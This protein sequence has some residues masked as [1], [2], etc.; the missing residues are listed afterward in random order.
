MVGPGLWNC[1]VSH[2]PSFRHHVA[3]NLNTD[4]ED[5][6][7]ESGQCPYN[8][9]ECR[10]WVDVCGRCYKV[11]CDSLCDGW[12]HCPMNDDEMLCGITCPVNCLCQVFTDNYK[13]CCDGM[14]PAA[15]DPSAC[16]APKDEISSCDDLLPSWTYR[17]SL[18]L[19]ACLSVTGNGFCFW[20]RLL[21][22]SM[23]S[24]S[25]FGVFVTNLTIADFLMGVYIVIIGVADERSRGKYLHYDEAWKSSVVCKAAGFLSLLSSEVSALIICVIT[26]DRFLVLRFP[27]STL[28][29]SRTSAAIACLF[30]WLVG[31]LLAS[32]PLLPVTLHWKFY[33]R[34][35]I[36]IPLPI[37]GDDFKGRVYSFSVLI[38]LNFVLFLFIS[39][40]QAFIYWSVQD[41]AMK[42]NT[43]RMS[44]DL[45]IARRLI[46][47]AISDFMCWFPIGVCGMLALAGIPIPG[48]VNVSLAVFILPLNSAVNPFLYTF[49]TL[50]EKQRKAEHE[51]LLKWLTLHSDTVT[52]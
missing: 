9:P 45:T 41:N 44:R 7:D 12:P 36:C 46:S 43:T 49:N 50:A 10:E 1:S 39:A 33:S 30:V 32:V 31:L 3:C 18:W 16:H 28:R 24:P 21:V 40:G 8:H 2:Y 47:V 37:M 25:G 13:L 27:F 42:T 20:A 4:C 17:G 38:A 19:M 11:L 26:L 51:R 23:A 34:T 14:L 52:G 29:F 48:K 5:G 35:G 6:R 22:K 15:F